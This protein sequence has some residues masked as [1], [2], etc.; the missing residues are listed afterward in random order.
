M[1]NFLQLLTMPVWIG[2]G[3]VTPFGPTFDVAP[4][5]AYVPAWRL[6]QAMPPTPVFQPT[7]SSVEI[8]PLKKATMLHVSPG[9]TLTNLIQSLTIPVC[10]GMGVATPLAPTTAVG[11]GVTETGLVTPMHA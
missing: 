6:L 8:G 3:V 5:Q 11:A 2:R 10:V 1:T 4:M 9:L 7:N